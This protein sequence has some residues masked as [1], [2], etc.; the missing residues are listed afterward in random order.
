VRAALFAVVFGFLALPSV[1]RAG[2]F[3]VIDSDPG[4][5][6]AMHLRGLVGISG[7]GRLRGIAFTIQLTARFTGTLVDRLQIEASPEGARERSE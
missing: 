3:L 4:D 7:A 5:P 2:S 6:I 1:A